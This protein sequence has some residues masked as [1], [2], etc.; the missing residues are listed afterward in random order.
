MN[1]IWRYLLLLMPLF[2]LSCDV[3]NPEEPTPAYLEVNEFTFTTDQAS[4][5]SN[6]SKITEGWVFVDGAFLGVYDLPALIPV[7]K[8]GPVDI[9]IE[10][11]IKE[12]GRRLTPDIY[13]FY[14][15]FD[16]SLDLEANKTE[17][18][19]PSTSY[20]PE[21]KISFIE[22]FED[23]RARVFTNDIS[24]SQSIIRNSEDVFEGEYS[25][26]FHLTKDN[27]VV[28][29]STAIS[30]SDLMENGVYVYL[31]INYKSEAYVVW[32]V[33]GQQD[34]V[35]GLERYLESGFQPK[36]EWN[37]IYLN[38]SPMIV[39]SKLDEYQ[40]ALQGFLTSESPDSTNVLIDNIKL[41]HF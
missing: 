39:A 10:A 6:S 36:D 14:K 7:L 31:E 9:R 18:I 8:T 40:I 38:I 16:V 34:P 24:G 5:G 41:V 32:G 37:K 3:I 21:A 1:E 30:F 22:N 12:N 26:Q 4:Q 2:L 27:S 15:P 29:F 33:V 25:G 20:L 35:T 28:E 11:G 17:I 19:N 23:N 13:P